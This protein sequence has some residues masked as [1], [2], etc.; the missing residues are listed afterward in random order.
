MG[1]PGWR[2]SPV[3]CWL[4]FVVIW[5]LRTACTEFGIS[6][7]GAR[8]ALLFFHCTHPEKSSLYSSCPAV[9]S[10]PLLRC[11]F[12]H[13]L[14]CVWHIPGPVIVL[15]PVDLAHVFLFGIREPTAHQKHSLKCQVEGDNLVCPFNTEEKLSLW[16]SAWNFGSNN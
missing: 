13:L 1:L 3:T 14:A 7:D 16:P 8:T 6:K 5:V 11:F 12:Q 2:W 10:P 4:W 15:A 9:K